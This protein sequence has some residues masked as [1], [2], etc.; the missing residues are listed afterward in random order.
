MD[1]AFTPSPQAASQ[2]AT[3]SWS[4][5]MMSCIP[6]SVLLRATLEGLEV[7]EAS[8]D[9]WLIAGG[10]RRRRLRAPVQVADSMKH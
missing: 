7:S 8:F 2:L 5:L 10:E 3:Q 1:L 9:A 4:T 6:Q